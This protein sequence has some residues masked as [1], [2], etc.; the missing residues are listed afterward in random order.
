VGRRHRL[1]VA[2]LALL[3][4]VTAACS[5]DDGEAGSTTVGPSTTIPND[6]ALV[7]LL[8][9]HDELPDGFEEARPEEDTVPTFCA[10]VDATAGLRATGRAIAHYDREVEPLG[11]SIVDIVFRF[12]GDGAAAFVRQAREAFEQCHEVPDF[13]GLAFAF[14]PASDALEA[15]LAGTD[16]HVARHGSSVG[17]GVLQE[18]IAV[19]HRGDVAHFVAV[20]T[21]SRPAAELEALAVTVFAA[22]AD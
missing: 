16:D 15:E 8:V 2:V 12:E 14:S 20:F 22:A 13:S 1:L 19:F 9:Q 4:L 7:P 21:S 3:P 18:E 6:P 5:D 17:S 11:Q 10:G